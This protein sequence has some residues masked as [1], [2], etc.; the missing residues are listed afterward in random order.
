MTIG[1][2]RLYNTKNNNSY[3]GQSK[4]ILRRLNYHK[5]DLK[6]N[7]HHCYKLQ[8]EYNKLYKEL[9]KQYKSDPL[10]NY[11][12]INKIVI[13]KFYKLEVLKEFNYYNIDE[14]LKVEDEYI[15]K[16]RDIQEGY[17]QNTN[18]ELNN[19]HYELL[20]YTKIHYPD[21]YDYT[22]D[23]RINDFKELHKKYNIE[24][25]PED[26]IR[27]MFTINRK[28]LDEFTQDCIEIG[29]KHYNDYIN[30]FGEPKYIP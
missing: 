26:E 17:R 12:D 6:N 13:D 23:L 20:N 11:L 15:L 27:N 21:L 3:I 4:D 25:L 7:T 22:Y 24:N 10:Y 28:L 8:Q 19:K 9:D 2:Y 14:L 29:K 1:I 5:E 30:K 16:F 18:E